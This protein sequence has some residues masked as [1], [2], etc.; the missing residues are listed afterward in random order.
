RHA[1]RTDD[2]IPV[3]DRLLHA[4]FLL[5]AAGDGA[6]AVLDPVGNRRPA[7]VLALADDVHLVAATRAVLH[8]PEL[9]GN[10]MQRRR[11]DV[12]VTDRPDLQAGARLTDERVVFGNGAIGIDPHDL[13]VEADQ[14]LRLHAAFGDRPVSLRDE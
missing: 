14:V 5:D 11:L 8:F 3:V 4:L 10:G 12:A 7:V 6:A 2:G 1:A 13:A 9:A